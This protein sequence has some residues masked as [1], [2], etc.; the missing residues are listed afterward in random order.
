MRL[1]TGPCF[2]LYNTVL[3]AMGTDGK[4]PPFAFPNQKWAGESAK[5]RFV[6]TIYTLNDGVIKLAEVSFT[7]RVCVPASANPCRMLRLCYTAQ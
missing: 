3:R 6:C 2:M 5:E 7:A 4:V 1:Y